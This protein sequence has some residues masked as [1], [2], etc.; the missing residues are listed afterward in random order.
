MASELAAMYAA[1]SAEQ[2]LAGRLE[3]ARA[4]ARWWQAMDVIARTG[5][6][7]PVLPGE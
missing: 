5:Q 1:R 3:A 2:L 7:P 6:A 4:A